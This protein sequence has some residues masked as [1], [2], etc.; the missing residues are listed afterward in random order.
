MPQAHIR[1]PYQVK[2]YLSSAEDF[3]GLQ[4]GA[5]PHQLPGWL[6]TDLDSNWT[7][8]YLNATKR[9]PFADEAFDYIVAEHIIE[10]ISYEDALKMLRECHRVLKKDGVVRISTP[11]MELT[12]RLMHPPLT[13]E[14][15]RYVLWSNHTY[16]GAGSPDSAIHVIN[17]LQHE[18]G[19]QFLYDA[20][21]LIAAF[22]RSGFIEVAEC[23]PGMSAHAALVNVDRHAEAIGEEFNELESLIVEAT[24]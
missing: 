21:T 12:H 9:F 24:K 23:S 15:Q 2:R 18:W 6:K 22:R 1:R 20:D 4:I 11:N 5:G 14:L 3:T 10:H 17:R 16:E 19:H 8:A 13:P 7:T